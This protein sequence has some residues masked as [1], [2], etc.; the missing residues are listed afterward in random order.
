MKNSREKCLVLEGQ[1][2]K[3]EN[4]ADELKEKLLAQ[5]A[6]SMRDNLTFFNIPEKEGEDCEKTLRKFLRREMSISREDMEKI[7]F[8]RVHR[9]GRARSGF[10]RIVV[11]KFS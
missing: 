2:T 10:N 11:A 4:E 7:V 8:D 1:L 6:R 9:T 3:A 5:E